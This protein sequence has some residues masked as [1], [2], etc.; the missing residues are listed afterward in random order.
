MKNIRFIFT[1]LL[2]L[3]TTVILAQTNSTYKVNGTTY[4]YNETY[5]TTGLPKVERSSSARQEFLN[6]RGYNKVPAGYQVD[7]IVPLSK[8][9]A[10]QPYNM[11]LLPTEQHKVK[12]AS[13]RSSST[14]TPFY[15]APSSTYKSTYS[16]PRSTYKS[17]FSTPKYN[18]TPTYNSG[19]GRTI[20]TGSRGGQYYYN[21]K[22]NKTYIK[23]R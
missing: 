11:Q 19:S 12:T 5:K 2:I 6:S 9:G 3:S 21:S 1:V 14:S 15:S 22:G 16:A 20:H 17:T 13:E 18:S 10:D 4:K 8:G 23:R 7:H